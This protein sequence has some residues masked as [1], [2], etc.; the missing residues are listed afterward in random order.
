MFI[1]D[2]DLGITVRASVSHLDG[3]QGNGASTQPAMSTDGRW[4]A[5]TSNANNLV[6]SDLNGADDVFIH[7]RVTDETI[8]VSVDSSGIEGD[9][10]SNEAHIGGDG[11]QFI[12]F[13]SE[14]SN[15]S[16]LDDNNQADI[17]MHDRRARTTI[18]VSIGNDGLIGNSGSN[19]PVITEDGRFVVFDS[20]STNMVPNDT[21]DRVDVFLRDLFESSTRLMSRS[22]QGVQAEFGS[23]LPDIT[24]AG[25]FIVFESKSGGL[26]PGDINGVTD[27]F[28]A[29]QI[30]AE[31]EKGQ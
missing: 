15:L 9:G 24:A 12:V 25:E 14:A 1:R 5:F 17:Y 19:N 26:V 20:R 27:V 18:L 23:K 16:S 10:A 11:G 28:V 21:N 29:P 22:K 31:E 7:D 30:P 8:R 3:D 13:K 6:L 4:V 2:G